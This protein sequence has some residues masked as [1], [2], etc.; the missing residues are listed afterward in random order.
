[1]NSEQSSQS[2]WGVAMMRAIEAE[3]PEAERICYDPY[4]RAFVPGIEYVLFKPMIDSGWYRRMSGGAVEFVIVRER[5]IDDCL[6]AALSAGLDQVV[7]LGAGF[8][9]RAYRIAGIETTR[10]FEV[11]HPATQAVKLKGLK[12]VSDPLPAHV[13]FVPID[14]DTQPLGERLLAAGYDE[15]GRTLFIWQGVTYFLTAAGVDSTLAFIAHHSGPGSAVIFDYLFNETLRDTQHGY[16]KALRRSARLS[17]EA[18]MFGIDQGQV[19]PFL[20]Q[21]GFA[22]VCDM[23]LEELKQRYFTGPNAGRPIPTGIDIVSA[24]VQR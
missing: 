10:V 20:A 15:R 12:K 24:T 4:A 5:Y 14:F 13:T 1:M 8:D 11:D 16:G 22:Q 7:I 3:K 17:G 19:E 18:Y 23:T 21:R 6:Q 9:T 2:A